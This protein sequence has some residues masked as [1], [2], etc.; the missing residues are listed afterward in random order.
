MGDFNLNLINFQHHQ[1]TGEFLDGL[2][3]YMFFAMIT[4]ATRITS[5]TVTLLDNSFANTFFYHSRSCLLKYLDPMGKILSVV[6]FTGDL[7]RELVTLCQNTMI[8]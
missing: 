8:F 6:L 5:H 2:H 1:N 7:I 4:R 3:S